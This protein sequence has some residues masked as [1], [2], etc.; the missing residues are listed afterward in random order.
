MGATADVRPETLSDAAAWRVLANSFP[1]I[2]RMAA[3]RRIPTNFTAETLIELCQD[4]ISTS[5]R[6]ICEFLLHVWNQYDFSFT[7]SDVR[8]WDEAHQAAFIGWVTGKTLGRAL[9]YF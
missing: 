6:S 8:T 2:A 3:W 1:C 9:R 4:A 7:L 5:E